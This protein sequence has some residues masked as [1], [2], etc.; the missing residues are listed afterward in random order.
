[1]RE[2]FVA[3][4]RANGESGKRFG[5]NFVPRRF[6][7]LRNDVVAR[8]YLTKGLVAPID[9]T[10]DGKMRNSENLFQPA[11][12]CFEF[13]GIFQF[14][15]ASVSIVRIN[16]FGG[17]DS[18]SISGREDIRSYEFPTT[19]DGGDGNDGVGLY[20]LRNVRFAVTRRR[21]LSPVTCLKH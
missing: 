9:R 19:I 3:P 12:G 16:V 13:G 7:D 11:Q 8:S 1:M 6:A 15:P 10:R 4:L 21:N 2:A 17:D 18:I 5:P 14:D 20:A